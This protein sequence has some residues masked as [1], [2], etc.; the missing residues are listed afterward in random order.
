MD[1]AHHGGGAA[2]VDAGRPTVSMSR[3]MRALTLGATL[4]L[5]T[6]AAAQD[7]RNIAL[8]NGRWFDG[9]TFAA[10][11]MYSVDG[12]F[13]GTPPA[14]VDTTIDLAGTWVVPPFGEAHNHNVDGAVEAR[15]R[16][17]L[18][19]Y[20]AD[21]VLYVQV[22]GNFPVGAELRR[23]LPMNRPGTPDVALAQAFVTSSGGHPV[24]LHE[25]VLL[26]RGWY[27]GFTRERLRDSLYVTVDDEKDL[28]D[29]WRR[30]RALRPDVVKA[31]LW[32]SDDHARRRADPAY[33][34][35]RGLDPRLLARLVTLAH[36][37]GL[38][39]SVHV[40]DAGDFR[41]A[42][43]AGVDQ[44]AHAGGPSF[45][46]TIEERTLDPGWVR[47]P[48]AMVG[49]L[50]AALASPDSA[51]SR[52]YVPV[53]AED[54]REAARRGIAVATTAVLLT[55]APDQGRAA[56]RPAV[57]AS[58][59]RLREH[60]VTLVVGSDD[61]DDTS[62]REIEQLATLGIWDNLGLLR[63]WSVDTP[64]AIFPGR[65]IGRLAD[66][67]EAS[68]LALDGNPLEDFASVRRIRLRFKQGVAIAL[69]RPGP[70]R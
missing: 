63:M 16:A 35:H 46:N 41:H 10:R 67:Y 3:A 20:V 13:S 23:R 39:V 5:A 22:Q 19:R 34:G 1:G 48:A 11:T 9:T 42:V 65:R 29:A 27:P 2:G 24:Q 58:L 45:F 36:R 52:G 47:D 44:I 8:V 4:G 28:E 68:F 61:P 26:P 54:A 66:G 59:R 6:A 53:A 69:D 18:A 62:L 30:I 60:G 25:D 14:R 51:G 31:V 12:V 55:R 32:G 38:R 17:A 43:A 7:G 56:L 50:L 40:N 37:D 15:S 49:M 64:R 70:A 21:G 57:A 33:R